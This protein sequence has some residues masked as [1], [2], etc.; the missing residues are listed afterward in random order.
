MSHVKEIWQI[1]KKKNKFGTFSQMGG[2][3]GSLF[4]NYKWKWPKHLLIFFSK[5]K[6]SL[7]AKR[8]TKHKIYFLLMGV[9][10]IGGRGGYPNLGKSPK[11]VSFF[12]YGTPNQVL[13]RVFNLFYDCIMFY[14][15]L[16]DYRM[17]QKVEECS[18][19]IIC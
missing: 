2:G 14:N 9:P 18:N 12:N 4:P 5:Q 17:F 13:V 6:W 7:H 8:Q 11:Y 1:S 3:G 10:N 19:I 16:D 15:V